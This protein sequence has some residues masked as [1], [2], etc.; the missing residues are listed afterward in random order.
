VVWRP[1]ETLPPDLG[2]FLH[3]TGPDGAIYG[4][5]DRPAL[6]AEGL[7][8][9]RF[10]VTPRPGT[11]DGDLSVVFGV[12]SAGREIARLPVER[13]AYPPVTRNPLRRDLN[14]GS[15]D[16]LIGYDWDHT[17]EGKS[18]L[19]LHWAGGAS[20]GYRTQIVDEWDTLAL[21][22][23]RGPWGVTVAQWRFP[24]G[25]DGGHY[26]PLGNGIVWTGETLNNV[27]LSPGESTVLGEEFRSAR[28]LNRDL[29][30]SVRLIGLEPDGFHWAWWDLV[31][32]VPA[33][34]AI[35]TLK[36]I[37]NSFVRSPHRVTASLHAPPGQK[38][39]GALTL[40]DAF[41]NRPLAILDER[42]TAS[43]PWIPLCFGEVDED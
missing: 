13:N 39:T 4:Q 28:P 34:G 33:M 17:L 40:Y 11:P 29:V 20:G 30:V 36:W 42:I 35:P 37:T 27:V 12:G 16:S 23:Y 8:V 31:D 1:A 32:S 43:Q 22:P 21:P 9:T 24:R 3:L 7:T 15:N 10:R 26:V 38:L 2:L 14:D 6:A 18:R 19:Y 25:A 5:D 41:T